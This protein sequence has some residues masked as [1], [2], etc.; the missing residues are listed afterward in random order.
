MVG[1]V[2]RARPRHVRSPPKADMCGAGGYVRFGPQEDIAKKSMHL[3]RSTRALRQ[4]RAGTKGEARV[5]LRCARS[6]LQRL[7]GNVQKK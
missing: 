2:L 6:D 1:L 4:A 5:D 7:I 3:G